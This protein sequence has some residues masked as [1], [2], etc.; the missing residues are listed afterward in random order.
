GESLGE[1]VR[2]IQ[3]EKGI[4]KVLLS[5]GVTFNSII[6]DEIYKSIN[7]K[8]EHFLT[9]EKISPGDGGISVGQVYLKALEEKGYV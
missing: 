7:P 8:K 6:V 3:E 1:V 2:R 9:N 5:G 4:N